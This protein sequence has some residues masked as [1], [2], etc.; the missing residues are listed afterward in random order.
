MPKFSELTDAQREKLEISIQ[1]IHLLEKGIPEQFPQGHSVVRIS[2]TWT[3]IMTY[4]SIRLEARYL[5]G[6]FVDL[7]W[8]AWRPRVFLRDLV[9]E[10]P[11]SGVWEGIEFALVKI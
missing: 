3:H 7:D 1:C 4:K 10:G 11:G 2:N 9:R 5:K 6:D 8:L